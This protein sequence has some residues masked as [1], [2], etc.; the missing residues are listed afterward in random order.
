MAQID[1]HI[2]KRNSLSQHLSVGKLLELL[3]GGVWVFLADLAENLEKLLTVI[4]VRVHDIV[5]TIL[6]LLT[7]V[8]LDH[9]TLLLVLLVDI[10]VDKDTLVGN[11]GP[12]G[13]DG[14]EKQSQKGL[15]WFDEL[16]SVGDNNKVKP[17]IGEN[18]PDGS[19]EE[20]AQVLNLTDFIIGN[21]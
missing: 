15:P 14:E 8:L 13:Q 12:D 21:D 7:L 3:G 1:V 20:N 9:V 5:D 19:D 10:V 6:K 4:E 2:L 11:P 18:R 16:L 17:N